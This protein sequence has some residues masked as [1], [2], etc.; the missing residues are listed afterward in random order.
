MIWRSSSIRRRDR[1]AFVSRIRESS[2]YITYIVAPVN[3]AVIRA[4]NATAVAGAGSV[5]RRTRDSFEVLDAIPGSILTSIVK[6]IADDL[7]DLVRGEGPSGRSENRAAGVVGDAKVLTEV[8]VGLVEG[9]KN[10]L[11]GAGDVHG[12]ATR[13]G[14]DL[15]GDI[16]DAVAGN[17]VLGRFSIRSRQG[18]RRNSLTAEYQYGC[19]QKGAA[20]LPTGLCT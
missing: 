10:L 11:N 7:L 18:A 9:I 6:H 2:R 15:P 4:A 19:T 8:G 12:R 5:G 13:V 17:G 14:L 20:S 16:L 3:G 1:S